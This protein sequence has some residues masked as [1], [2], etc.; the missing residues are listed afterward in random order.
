M[1]D[2]TP[3]VRGVLLD[4]LSYIKASGQS[5]AV[6][7]SSGV[8]SHSIL[9]ACI[10]LEI[11]IEVYSFTLADRESRDFKYA[12]ATAEVFGATF[13]KVALPI[14]VNALKKFCLYAVKQG[15]HGKTDFECMW[16]MATAMR[17]IAKDGHRYVLS[18]TAADS[19][20]ALSKKANMKFKDRVDEYR[21]LVFA[22]RNTGQ[23]LLLRAEAAKLGMEYFTPY[24]TTRMCSELHGYTWE[25]LNKPQQKQPIRAAFPE[26]FKKCKTTVHTNLQLGDSGIADHFNILLKSDWNQWGYKSVKG[27]YNRLVLG[28]LTEV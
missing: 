2:R 17:Q 23:K 21:R 13:K 12:R 25:Q 24:D 28:E 15:A 6:L 11:P 18:A 10:E 22:K 19:H 3:N 5:A 1:S 16:P 9:F 27:I 14:S 7:L 26:Y 20:F 8:D 4:E